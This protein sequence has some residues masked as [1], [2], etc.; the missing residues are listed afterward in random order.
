MAIN[1][2]WHDATQRIVMFEFKAGWTA[3]DFL[4]ASASAREM[5]LSVQH[6]VAMIVLFQQKIKLPR[7]FFQSLYQIENTITPN[8]RGAAIVHD[9]TLAS[10]TIKVLSTVFPKL[11]QYVTL[12][13]DLASAFDVV[14][15][16]MHDNE[17]GYMAV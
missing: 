12:V 14:T 3:D 5:M 9:S 2:F 6:P 15:E 11:M 17:N 4:R 16:L 1:V 10:T 8:F 7:G 13:P